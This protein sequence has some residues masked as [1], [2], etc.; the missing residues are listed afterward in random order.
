MINLNMNMRRSAG[1]DEYQCEGCKYVRKDINCMEEHDI[2]NM[3]V[4]FCLNCDD[5]IKNK[6][7]VFEHGWTM[8]DDAGFLRTDV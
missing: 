7:A 3:R 5:W 6:F 8:F 2:R 1:T 4:F